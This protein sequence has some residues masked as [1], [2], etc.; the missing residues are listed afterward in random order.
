MLLGCVRSIC[1]KWDDEMNKTIAF[2]CLL[3]VCLFSS[4]AVRYA[5]AATANAQGYEK[6]M[7]V[8]SLWKYS[9]GEQQTIAFLDTGITK[10]AYDL[11][12]GRMVSPL[13][14]LDDSTNGEDTLGH[15]TGLISIACG[16]GQLGIVGIAPHATILP[17]KAIGE[18]G[19]IDAHT[20]VKGIRAA[21]E[22]HATV[23]N[24]SFGSHVED[25]EVKRAIED[26]LS[27]NITVLASAGDYGQKDLLFPASQQGVI[28]V[29]ALGENG[30]LWEL[31]N[32]AEKNEST[33]PGTNIAMLT[34]H[35]AVTT[36]NGTSYACALASGYVALMRSYLVQQRLDVTNEKIMQQMKLLNATKT[37]K[38]D[39]IQPLED[40]NINSSVNAL[41]FMV[42]TNPYWLI[43][44]L[45]ILVFVVTVVIQRYQAKAK[46]VS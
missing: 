15:G 33:F 10:E 31:S 24:L 12:K 34:L 28:S 36:G 2:L 26:A 6:A 44:F 37:G 18:N 43:T 14:V 45:V 7:Q 11:Y 35:N 42:H 30:Q 27:K 4:P 22:H 40:L 5:S 9:K 21:I 1:M 39:Y 20:I 32:T 41:K 46:R 3:L 16:D 25:A 29:E 17:I 8:A 23:I 13:N 19:K 38:M